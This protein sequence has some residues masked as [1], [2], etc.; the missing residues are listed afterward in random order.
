VLAAETPGAADATG[1]SMDHAAEREH[2]RRPKRSCG[3]AVTAVTAAR[4]SRSATGSPEAMPRK[5]A[6]PSAVHATLEPPWSAEV[7]H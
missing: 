2:R 3:F 1:A 7:T 5:E 6:L 4:L